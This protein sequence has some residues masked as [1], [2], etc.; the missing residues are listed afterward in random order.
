MDHQKNMFFETMYITG[1][2]Y[3]HEIIT[4]QSDIDYIALESEIYNYLMEFE[5]FRK[6]SVAVENKSKQAALRVWHVAH[7]SKC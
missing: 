2:D 1:R 3:G 6:Y 7:G 5:A 4:E